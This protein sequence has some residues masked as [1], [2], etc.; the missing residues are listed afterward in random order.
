MVI[1]RGA[2]GMA[3]GT[4][5]WHQKDRMSIRKTAGAIIS[6]QFGTVVRGSLNATRPSSGSASEFLMPAH[7]AKHD[8]PPLPPSSEVSFYL[9]LIWQTEAIESFAISR[10]TG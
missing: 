4:Q 2:L 3:V 5:S 10:H 6:T 7:A 9:T 1:S 8:S